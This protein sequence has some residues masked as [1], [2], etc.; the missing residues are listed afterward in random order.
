MHVAVRR[1]L[2]T[3]SCLLTTALLTACHAAPRPA[4]APTARRSAALIRL[5]H[6]IDALL[7][8]PELERGSWGVLVKSLAHDDT[9]YSLNA[10]KLLMP[11]SNM[12]IVKAAA[13]ERLGWDYTYETR[14]LGVGAIDAGVLDGDLLVVGSGDPRVL[15][16]E[17][18]AA[19]VF[20]NWAEQLKAMGVRAING[21]IVGDDTA[22]DTDT[23]A[24]LVGAR[25]DD[26]EDQQEPLR[27][28]VAEDG[29]R[30][31]G[32]TDGRGR[33]RRDPIDPRGLGRAAVW[34]D[35][36]RRVG[37]VALQ[38]RD[39]RNVGDDPHP[40]RSRRAMARAVRGGASDRGTRR[41]AGG[42]DGGNGGR[43][44]RARQDRGDG[45]RPRDVRLRLYG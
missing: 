15:D 16:G 24:A 45:Q 38:L 6:D 8:A 28:N 3:V 41:D 9:L 31:L 36:S 7:A 26:D 33:S 30:R 18:S 20:D 27:R 39:A 25:D 4:V 42:P 10:R 13:A 37:V 21:G 44:E 29:G 35:S 40:R 43:G 5:Q 22:F 11:A 1:L 17:D 32:N 19:P 2:T 14:V 34:A 23:L 12:K